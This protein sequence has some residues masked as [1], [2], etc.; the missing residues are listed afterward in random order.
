MPVPQRG[1]GFFRTGA[2]PLPEELILGAGCALEVLKGRV[3]R[4]HFLLESSPLLILGSSH[5][6]V[7]QASDRRRVDLSDP[8]LVVRVVLY[9]LQPD[10]T[11]GR[12][13]STN[14]VR[15][16]T[17]YWLGDSVQTVGELV[18]SQLYK[19]SSDG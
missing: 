10:L 3:S 18:C 14:L 11:N 17:I 8:L 19:A 13:I 7:N 15:A 4:V 1:E 16:Q 6:K 9:L 5:N 2:G 12:A